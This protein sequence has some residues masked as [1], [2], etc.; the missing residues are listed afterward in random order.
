MNLVL[1]VKNTPI[2]DLPKDSVLLKFDFLWSEINKDRFEYFL[3]F[4]FVAINKIN[5]FFILL[6]FS[7][8]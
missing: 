1:G 5:K 7:Y 4:F 2:I 3:K 6:F 8:Y